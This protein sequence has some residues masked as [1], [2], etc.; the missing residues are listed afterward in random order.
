[1]TEEAQTTAATIPEKS[2]KAEELPEQSEKEPTIEAAPKKRGRPAGSKDTAPRKP[3]VKIV[4]E[5][6]TPPPEPDPP[7]P[8][9]A[10]VKLPV[11]ETPA[12]P[13]ATAAPMAPPLSPRSVFRHASEHI[14]LLQSEREKAR[15]AYWMDAVAKTLR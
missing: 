13:A 4:E 1:M 7:E 2:E 14:S 11:A 9:K 15:K 10:K 3:R 12:V 6:P 5:P 8:K